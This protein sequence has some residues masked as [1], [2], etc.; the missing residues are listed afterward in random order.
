MR[1]LSWCVLLLG[2]TGCH[3]GPHGITWQH[4]TRDSDRF[5]DP[6]ESERS[7][8]P[9][10]AAEIPPSPDASQFPPPAPPPE[11]EDISA[12]PLADARTRSWFSVRRSDSK[13]AS[14]SVSKKKSGTAAK[15]NASQ[16]EAV[17]QMTAR[18]E[19]AKRE[20]AKQESML[21]DDSFT[22]AQQLELEARVTVLQEQLRQQQEQLQQQQEQL[23]QQSALQ[24]VTYQQQPA[25][26]RPT[27]TTT[28]AL[29]IITTGTP[30]PSIMGSQALGPAN[31]GSGIPASSSAAPAW[32]SPAPTWTSPAPA[33]TSPAPAWNSPAM[34]DQSSV[35][36]WPF[37]PQGR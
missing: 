13:T 1:T 31:V 3:F 25:A 17:K 16:D 22:H 21:F 6:T 26:M 10:P 27:T 11:P 7:A 30:S 8:A 12:D 20:K 4:T 32:N 36:T 5:A 33:W 34:P 37:S 19:R 23:R 15:R 35:E 2:L 29:P 28:G 14:K 24:Q 9:M 18:L